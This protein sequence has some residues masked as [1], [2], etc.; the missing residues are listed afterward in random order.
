MTRKDYKAIALAIAKV[1]AESHEHAVVCAEVGAQLMGV[2]AE[3]NPR[4]DRD[5]FR[6]FYMNALWEA[7]AIKR[8]R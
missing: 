8:N 2:F 6:D 1:G 7:Q 4:F 5:T 3:D